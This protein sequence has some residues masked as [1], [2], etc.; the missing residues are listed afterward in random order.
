MS[1]L[2][3]LFTCAMVLIAIFI[4][5]LFTTV[6]GFSPSEI[7][8]SVA[9][10]LIGIYTLIYY[11]FFKLD[12]SL[13]YGVLLIL[14]AVSTAYRHFSGLSFARGYPYYIACFAYAHFAVFVVFRQYIHCKIFA[15]LGIEVILLMSYKIN[16]LPLFALIAINVGFLALVAFNAC[17]RVRRNLRRE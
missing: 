11:K 1:R 17:I 13:Y 9:M 16:L 15:I 5:S 7:W 4:A 6:N 8:F 2:K 10:F 12:S 3:I 14:L